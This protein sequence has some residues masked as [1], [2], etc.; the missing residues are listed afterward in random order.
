MAD[1]SAN[2]AKARK[3]GYSDA[4]IAAHIAKDPAMGSKVTSARKAGYSDAE[5]I[6]HLGKPNTAMDVAKS[7]GSGLLKAGAGLVDTIAQA[8]PIGQISSAI[9][10]AADV[11]GNLSNFVRVPTL[12]ATEYKKPQTLSTLVT[13]KGSDAPQGVQVPRLAAP[14]SFASRETNRRAYKPQTTAG[15]VSQTV[16]QNVP[17]AFVPASWGRR[18]VNV[19]APAFASEAAGQTARSMG[20]DTT[21]EAMAR[22]G[23]ALFGAGLASVRPGNLFR[24]GVAP[25]PVQVMG[26]RAV[27]D[28]VE[29][30]SEAAR[31]RSQGV[32]P[33]LTDVG[34]ESGRRFLRAVGVKG[35]KAGEV[36]TSRAATTS[37]AV[38]PAAMVATR[39]LTP[40]R[41]TAT[42]YA[43][44]METARDVEATTNYAQFDAEPITIP[45]SV[46][47]ML[48][49]ASGRSIIARA[50]A[51]AVENQDWM[52]QA[53]LDSLLR[54]T[55]DGQLPRVSAGTVDRLVIAA[56]ERGA[57]FAERGNNMRARGAFQRRN[58]LDSTLDNVDA[59]KP[60]RQAYAEK[61][62]AVDVATGKNWLDPQT[63]DP[64]D[65]A[66]WL[67][68]LPPEALNA[69]RLKIRQEILD[70]LG[71]QKANS[72]GTLDSLTTSPYARENL[73]QAFGER[74]A[75]QFLGQIAA[76]LEQTRN[77][78]FVQP[79]AG[80]RTAV[81]ENDTADLAKRG[82]EAGR[83]VFRG[84]AIGLV[85]SGVDM[86]LRR[87]F[88]KEQAEQLARIASDATQTDQA[89]AKIAEALTPAARKDFL[90][91]RNAARIGAV[92]MA[93]GGFRA[94]NE[95][96]P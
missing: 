37:S 78:S 26:K 94:T 87:G 46:K 45:D 85:Q 34:G 5:I 80:S 35:D 36:L 18:A 55:K 83:Q 57:K 75:E 70:T 84:D 33:T 64:A 9:E 67:R 66:D 27:L 6:A 20:A 62:R 54:V 73:R 92:G 79:N 68:S 3:A 63:N 49:D 4:E 2:I 88:S 60:S 15:E 96:R 81:V 77:A 58:Q 76:R 38:K 61:S 14:V 24:Q 25:E 7:F 31:L 74:E 95:E 28:P 93:T 43:E 17:N 65:Y 48:A 56:R 10:T 69:N 11:G 53:E 71:P 8:S 21:G 59:L 50:R 32:E 51:D 40:D 22:G 30:R 39:R 52:R 23:G 72:F 16:A 42:Q 89:I 44:E 12:A 13:G 86:F 1:L 29:M 91:L 82:I 19:F 47:D 90:Q 41:R